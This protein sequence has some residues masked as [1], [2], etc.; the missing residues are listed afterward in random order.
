[1]ADLSS[2]PQADQEAIGS[3]LITL[4]TGFQERDAEPL[5]SVL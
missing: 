1:M 4:R 3:T 5:M 2:L